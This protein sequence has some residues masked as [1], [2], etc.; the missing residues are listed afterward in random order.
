M[1]SLTQA[2]L[3]AAVGYAVL[4]RQVGCKAMIWGAVVATVPDLDVFVPLGDD[5]ANFTQHRSASHSLLV[6]ALATPGIAWIIGRVHAASYPH[7][8]QR[9]LLAFLCLVTHAL[10]DGLTVY[11]TQLLW[12]LPVSPTTWSTLFIID[13]A[14]TL[15]LI[16]GLAG[17]LLAAGRGMRWNHWGLALSSTYILF[18][19]AAKVQVDRI[20]EASL[21][22]ESVG[23]RF[24]SMATPFNALLWRVVAMDEGTYREGYYSLFDDSDRMRFTTYPANHELLDE[25]AGQQAVRRLRW[26]TKGFFAVKQNGMQIHMLDL[27]MGFEPAYVFGF[28]VGE[29]REG[30]V[31]AVP[32]RRL[33]SGPDI[34]TVGWVWRRILDESLP[35]P[36]LG[37]VE[38][39]RAYPFSLAVSMRS[40]N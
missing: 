25:L 22:E 15:P 9:W 13:P 33:D 1:D 20:A 19:I 32:N 24:I 38:E 14:Y 16:V 4:G 27:R 12:P 31:V 2:S 5:V 23:S 34:M 10:L 8:R 18:T 11:G 26:F 7:R 40:T 36:H 37:R 21:A 17:G 35:P 39:S 6:H 30:G 29:I 28:Q 3:G